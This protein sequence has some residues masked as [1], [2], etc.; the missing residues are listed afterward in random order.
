MDYQ[1]GNLYFVSP[2]NCGALFI[3]RLPF[4]RRSADI[5]VNNIL[6]I[7]ALIIPLKQIAE[8]RNGDNALNSAVLTRRHISHHSAARFS[9][10]AEIGHVYKRKIILT[11]VNQFDYIVQIISAKLIRHLRAVRAPVLRRNNDIVQ[12]GAHICRAVVR[13]HTYFFVSAAVIKNA[14]ARLFGFSRGVRDRNIRLDYAAVGKVREFV[15]HAFFREPV[16]QF[17]LFNVKNLAAFVVLKVV[18]P[19]LG[20]LGFFRFF[21]IF[22]RAACRK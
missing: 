8:R 11:Q 2:V 19:A 18:N 14:L 13:K 9:R 7:L 4:L 20:A 17:N 21:R 10:N 16:A 15:G 1:H 22:G 12:Y 6:H 5:A 3:F